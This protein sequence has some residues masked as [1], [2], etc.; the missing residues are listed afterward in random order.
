LEREGWR[1]GRDVG[2]GG[3]AWFPPVVREKWRGIG[4]ARFLDTYSRGL[5]AIE[6]FIIQVCINRRVEASGIGG[7]K[8]RH[9]KHLRRDPRIALPVLSG[10]F[11]G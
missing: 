11:A 3:E 2:T 6:L 8:V 7:R 10:I 5:W 9:T 1:R 4:V